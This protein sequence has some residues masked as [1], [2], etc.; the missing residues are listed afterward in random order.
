MSVTL[1]AHSILSRYNKG[2]PSPYPLP[3][4]EREGSLDSGAHSPFARD[5]KR[6]KLEQK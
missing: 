5:A 6:T 3:Q 2:Y 4:G 1:C